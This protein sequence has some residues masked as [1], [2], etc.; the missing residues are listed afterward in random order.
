MLLGILRF[1]NFTNHQ[2]S[3]LKSGTGSPASETQRDGFSNADPGFCLPG[4]PKRSDFLVFPAFQA[5]TIR[6]TYV[7]TGFDMRQSGEL[8]SC[9]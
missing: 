2:N 3:H 4:F 9:A 7:G 5:Q 6:R 1:A 8:Y